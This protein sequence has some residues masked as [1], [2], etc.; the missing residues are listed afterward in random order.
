MF[1][2]PSGTGPSVA[3]RQALRR[4]IQKRREEVAS[5]VGSSSGGPAAT[6]EKGTTSKSNRKQQQPTTVREAVWRR[7]PE[8]S[9]GGTKSKPNMYIDHL[10]KYKDLPAKY[11]W[12]PYGHV[13]VTKYAEYINKTGEPSDIPEPLTKLEGCKCT[14]IWGTVRNYLAEYVSANMLIRDL[15]WVVDMGPNDGAF[16]ETT[17]GTVVVE[18]VKELVVDPAGLMEWSWTCDA[19]LPVTKERWASV[20]PLSLMVIKRTVQVVHWGTKPAIALSPDNPEMKKP[21]FTRDDL[22]WDYN[23]TPKKAL[24]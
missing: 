16:M 14:V 2:D 24:P 17:T 6:S 22:P 9:R 15:R 7:I 13:A 23:Q 5:D 19:P 3:S 4:R 20:K 1:A 18:K 10:K 8:A 11:D 21:I 12:D